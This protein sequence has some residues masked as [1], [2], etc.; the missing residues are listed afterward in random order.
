MGKFFKK[1]L[2]ITVAVLLIAG[3]T[4][5][6]SKAPIIHS[7]IFWIIL[8][9]VLLTAGTY[10]FVVRGLRRDLFALQNRYM[11]SLAIRLLL[12]AACIILYIVLVKTAKISF[13]LNFFA[14]YFV[15]TVFEI[16]SLLT[17]LRAHLKNAQ[18]EDEK[19]R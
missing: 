5:Y 8:Y 6:I 15:Y 4:P 13:V 1:L 3:I 11:A 18:K 9:F 14:V 12:S 16:R 19:L 10:L 17:N 2:F 7:Y